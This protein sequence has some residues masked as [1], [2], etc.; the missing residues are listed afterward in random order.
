VRVTNIHNNR[1]VASLQG[2]AGCCL[3]PGHLECG[4]GN[5]NVWLN[6]ISGGTF[7]KYHDRHVAK[8]LTIGRSSL[9]PKC[10]QQWQDADVLRPVLVQYCNS[11][12]A[13][14]LSKR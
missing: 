8:W 10:E 3:R 6:W 12:S 13:K 11:S 9:L 14:H 5:V 7:V 4:R 1:V 2:A